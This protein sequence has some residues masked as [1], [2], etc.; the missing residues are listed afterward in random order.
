MRKKMFYGVLSALTLGLAA[1]S[2]ND[3]LA[4][5][6][7][8]N[9]KAEYD[10]T[11]YIAVQI[12]APSDA[13]TR[14]FE[15]EHGTKNESAVNRLDF[16]FYD[17]AGNPTS[18]PKT[19]EGTDLTNNVTFTDNTTANA[20]V[21]R[22]CTSV[23]PVALTQGQNFPSQVICIVNGVANGVNELKTL[24]LGDLIDV[25]RTYFRNGTSFLM[26]NS[27][28]YGRDVLTGRDNQ[29]L[30]AT[31]I[32][33]NSQLFGTEDDA[34]KAITNAEEAPNALVDI[35]VERVAA[36][37]GLTMGT[38][39]VVENYT[40]I[41]GDAGDGSTISLTF[42]PEYWAMNA[43]DNSIYLTKRYGVE[44]VNEDGKI[45]IDRLPNYTLIDDALS[46]GGF[47]TWNDKA[48]YRSYWGCSP[49]YFTDTYPD[50]SDDVNDLDGNTVPY[51]ST[52]YSYNAIKT[53]AERT[54][55]DALGK[56]ALAATDGGFAITN[57]GDAATG[58]IYTR[59][60]TVAKQRINDIANSN[61]AAAVASAVL[62][63]KYK[64]AGATGAAATFY[65]DRNAGTGGTYYANV[66]TAKNTLAA[67]Q[68]I[69]YTSAE[70]SSETRAEGEHFELAHPVKAVR[71]LAG[72]KL[73]GRLVTL[74]LTEEVVKNTDLY[75]YDIDA[76]NGDGAY[77]RILA[78]D[79]EDGT[80][81][82]LD[83]VNAQLLSVGYMDMFADGLAFFSVPIRHL[84][85]NDDYYKNGK[86]QWADM[87]SGSL[88]VVRN[89]VYNLTIS[90]IKGLG[91]ALRDPDQ[92]I[93][94]AKEEANQ[95]IAARLNILAWS[96]VPA[97]SV[98][99]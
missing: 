66:Q 4:T 28:Y 32:N 13:G 82:N 92:P 50:V 61:P 47:T 33:A 54:G 8:Q 86:Y 95:Y 40:L 75:Y 84:N 74:Q 3:D 55:D 56:Q 80:K 22:I 94:P 26:S 5:G 91:T 68:S 31:P 9:Q 69:V 43:T 46:K 97:W 63:G 42:T 7:S 72:T 49:S 21:T 37:V 35:Y 34:K 51:V 14:A 87:A 88:G 83:K 2:S 12:S 36:K 93:V 45:I 27:V 64:V 76:D 29:R 52:Y 96:V 73:S 78:E 98:E 81:A 10:Q 65:I 1:C 90:K 62:V 23:I 20:N 60:T 24:K 85:W 71:D 99:L 19:L 79:A 57:T 77:V 89:H 18:V 41:N 70:A 30:C 17:V 48:N 38:E 16:F 39:N 53:Q 15:F 67:R 58:Y 11:Q 59:E 25:T 44:K 6:A